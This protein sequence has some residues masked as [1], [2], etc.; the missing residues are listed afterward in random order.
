MQKINNLFFRCKK[1]F[2]L[3]TNTQSLRKLKYRGNKLN[4][5]ILPPYRNSSAYGLAT[6]SNIKAGEGRPEAYYMK[7]YFLLRCRQTSSGDAGAESVKKM[8]MAD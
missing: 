4:K 2:P 7:L 1:H 8:L 5:P 3:F 6:V